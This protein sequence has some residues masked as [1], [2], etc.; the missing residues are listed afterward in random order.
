MCNEKIEVSKLDAPTKRWL[1]IGALIPK[2]KTMVSQTPCR[3]TQNTESKKKITQP[4]KKEH[5]ATIYLYHIY[6]SHSF[7]IV[8]SRCLSILNQTCIMTTIQISTTINNSS[9]IKCFYTKYLIL[10]FSHNLNGR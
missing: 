5:K 9:K 1:Y 7:I 8:V 2:D 6:W 4:D 3:E 10:Y